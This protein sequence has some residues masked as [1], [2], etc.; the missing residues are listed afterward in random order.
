V[1]RSTRRRFSCVARSTPVDRQPL[2]VMTAG[3]CRGPVQRLARRSLRHVRPSQA[4]QHHPDCARKS[5]KRPA[6]RRGDCYRGFQ[7][8]LQPHRKEHH[9]RADDQ[10]RADRADPRTLDDR[11]KLGPLGGVLPGEGT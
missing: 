1:P 10:R 4:P 6:A 7:R 11:P 3:R 9:E 5:R 2:A 8:M